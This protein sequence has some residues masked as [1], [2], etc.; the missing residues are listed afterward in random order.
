MNE[1]MEIYTDGG[2]RERESNGQAVSWLLI[3]DM[4]H[5]QCSDKLINKAATGLTIKHTPGTLTPF[6]STHT[7]T[8]VKYSVT[9]IQ[10]RDIEGV[11][12]NVGCPH[13]D[14]S[15]LW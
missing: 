10:T 14:W 9:T 11:D 13:F 15:N 2:K 1:R 5:H 12:R 3:R 8:L 4:C 6:I 7:H